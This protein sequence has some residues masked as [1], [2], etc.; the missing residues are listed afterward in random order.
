[1]AVHGA[2]QVRMGANVVRLW[3][4]KPMPRVDPIMWVGSPSCDTI[5]N[6]C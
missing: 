1:M 4:L 6:N 2:G 5:S 3:T